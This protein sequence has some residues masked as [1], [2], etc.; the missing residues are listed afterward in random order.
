M[1]YPKT[2]AGNT[3][4]LVENKTWKVMQFTGLLD[5]N[6][7]EI[8]EGDVLPNGKTVLTVKWT[9]DICN[10]YGCV[11]W[12]VGMGGY[13]GGCASEMEVIGNIYENPELLNV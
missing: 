6:G 2:G 1:I 13:G 10:E 8:Y 5:K 12:N 4:D 3:N 11:G 7:K 9:E